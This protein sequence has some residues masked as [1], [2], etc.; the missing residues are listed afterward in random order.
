MM[1]NTLLLCGIIMALGLVVYWNYVQTVNAQAGDTNY[2][3]VIM[4]LDRPLEGLNQKGEPVSFDQLKGKVWVLAY[5]YTRCPAGCAGVMSIMK[6]VQEEFAGRD[7]FHL[8]ALTLDP[9]K[10]TSEWMDQWATERDMGGDDW[11]FMTGVGK[12]I[13]TYMGKYFRLVANKRTDPVEITT[14]G[15]W[16]HEFKLVLVD[17]TGAIRYYYDVLNATYGDDH[18]KKI[19][20]DIQRLLDDGPALDGPHA[21]K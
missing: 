14:Y 12:N 10:D 13:R 17:Q 6:E 21:K 4:R 18:R 5:V 3:P 8:V 15:E 11:W 7:D 9:D 1:R 19:V 20:K 16:E 2:L